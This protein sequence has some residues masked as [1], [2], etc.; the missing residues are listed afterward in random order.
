MNIHLSL[1]FFILQ[2][3]EEDPMISGLILSFGYFLAA[4][5]LLFFAFRFIEGVYVDFFAKKPLFTHFY[6]RLKSLNEKERDVLKRQFSFYNKLSRKHQRYFQHRVCRFID[7]VEFIGGEDLEIDEEKRILIAATATM[8]TFGY[9]NYH[10]NRLNKVIIYSDEYY[11]NLNKTYHKG[12]FNPGHRAIV[13]SWKDFKEGYEIEEDNLNLGI[14][15][16]VHAI[17]ISYLGTKSR[18]DVS[19]HIFINGLEKIKNLLETNESYESKM[20][21]AG[22]FRDYAFTNQFELIAVLVE[23]FIETPSVFKVEFPEVYNEI[24]QMLNFDF[25]GY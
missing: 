23:N 7:R 25:A 13:F 5:F 8:L 9:R 3:Q 2:S 16:F 18:N 21:T 6:L 15:E 24:R 10:I 14:H 19:A 11:S 1:I 17:H 12:E 22:Y 4:L 20:K